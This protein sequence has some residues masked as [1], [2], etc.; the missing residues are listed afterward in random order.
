MVNIIQFLIKDFLVNGNSLGEHAD[1]FSYT[2][3]ILDGKLRSF[4]TV[5]YESAVNS[6]RR[7]YV[8]VLIFALFK[9][10]SRIQE[11]P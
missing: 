6:C 5:N 4:G 1:L 10:W 7:C 8:S 11:S 3:G 9:T 2:K